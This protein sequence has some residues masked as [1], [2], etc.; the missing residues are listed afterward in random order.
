MSKRVFSMISMFLFTGGFSLYLIL[1]DAFKI[2]PS[3]SNSFFDILIK[4]LI[5]ILAGVLLAVLFIVI[6]SFLEKILKKDLIKW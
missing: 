5:A 6:V 4:F 2:M 1:D 3:T